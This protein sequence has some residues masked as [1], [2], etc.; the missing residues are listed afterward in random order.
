MSSYPKVCRC[1]AQKTL[2]PDGTWQCRYKCPPVSDLKAKKSRFKPEPRKDG[3]IRKAISEGAARAGVPTAYW[4][5]S[6]PSGMIRNKKRRGN[7]SP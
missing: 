5:A 4:G 3:D 2:Q 7:G 1:T 6:L